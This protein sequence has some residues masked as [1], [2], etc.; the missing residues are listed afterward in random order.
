MSFP[1]KSSESGRR[2]VVAM[3]GGVDS[4][5]AA[6]L[7][8]QQ[9]YEVIGIMMRLWSD[10]A[11]SGAPTVNRCCTPDQMADAR[12]VANHLNIPFFVL[13]TQEQFRSTIVQHFIDEHKAGRT[14]NPC[15]AC[16]RRIR[17]S[18]LLEHARALG[19]D[20]LATG[21]Y[22][23]IRKRNNRYE[24][25]KGVDPGKDQSYV[26]HVLN[27]EKLAR[28]LFPIGVFQKKR[29]RELAEEF[30]LPVAGKHDSQDLCFISDGNHRAFLKRH[31]ENGVVTGPIID[32][33]GRKLGEHDG[34]PFY[35]IGQRKGLGISADQPLYVLQKDRAKNAIVVG[36]PE[37]LE[38]EGFLVRDLNWIAGE[39]VAAGK[40]VDIK[41]RYKAT[42]VCGFVSQE[43]AGNAVVKLMRPVR[44]VTPGQGAVFYDGE[45]CLG[46][47]I[48]A[49]QSAQLPALEATGPNSEEEA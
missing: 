21:H 18:F 27:Q 3:S 19:A 46:G 16:N 45:I 13:D 4:S 48:I 35:T 37:A 38:Q 7:L 1:E 22:A 29:V 39:P 15:I 5:V 47:G 26:L 12:R 30:G 25:L 36:P 11:G 40:Q 44:G 32:Q 9:G 14:P 42:A 24:L 49:D 10:N 34:L 6:A 2:V 28:V 17:F 20:F 41:I 43:A 33:D 31:D 23:R 8:V